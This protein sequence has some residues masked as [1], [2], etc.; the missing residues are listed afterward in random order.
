MFI[1][2]LLRWGWAVLELLGLGV[3]GG[4]FVDIYLIR[5]LHIDFGAGLG[6]FGIDTW[7][8]RCFTAW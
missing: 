7:V 2:C 4:G 5:I 1:S 3:G 8:T 6:G